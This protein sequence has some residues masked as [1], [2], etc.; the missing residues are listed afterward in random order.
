M[1]RHAMLPAMNRPHL[2][3]F[4]ILAGLTL[5]ASAAPEKLPPLDLPVP[6]AALK[7]ERSIA[8]GVYM[9]GSKIG[10]GMDTRKPNTIDGKAC[11]IS[12]MEA[13][14]ELKAMD[15]LVRLDMADRQTFDAA[16]PHRLLRLESI[17]K[18]DGQTRKI[19]LTHRQDQTY[20]VEITEAGAS[21]KNPDIEMDL[22]LAHITSPEQWIID[23]ER[24][25][26]EKIGTVEFDQETLG[27][28]SNTV[29][30]VRM[31]DWIGPGGKLPVW[32][33]DEYDHAQKNDV[34]GC[35]R[36]TDGT[37]VKIEMAGAFEIRM[38]PEA[39]AKRKPDAQA[40]VFLA[41][42]IK[43][44]RKLGP[45]E[46]LTDL[47]VELSAPDGKKTPDLPATANQ[48]VTPG[49]DGSLTVRITPGKGTPQPATDADRADYLKSNLRYPADHAQ[50]K[51]LA[52]KAVAGAKSDA[53]KV[54]KLLAFTDRYLED[55]YEVEALSVMD[56]L[57]SR[58]G[59]CSA[60]ALLFTTLARAAGIPAREAWG[61]M[62][63]GDTYQSFGG[64]AWNEVILDGHWVPVDPVFQQ[65]R[66]DAGHIQSGSGATDSIHTGRITPGLR[67]TVK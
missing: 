52:A 28:S 2:A 37:M 49:D 3:V 12:T 19:I 33:I 35:V 25:P 45:A 14:I 27:L 46:K 59:E 44:N 63:M 31:A 43:T 20:A 62:Y 22:R 60:H 11:V 18:M 47:T 34:Q 42:S 1:P 57:K 9:Q 26:G 39:V 15:N 24:K 56:L 7:Q 51:A 23:P 65:I 6:P 66:L 36:R 53:D 10:W 32:E 54:R 55:S 48:T 40:D 61:W 21:R 8:Y 29:T 41:F 58:K 67:A 50:V 5:A 17:Q 64:H 16:P 4:P 13:H 30:L 38:E